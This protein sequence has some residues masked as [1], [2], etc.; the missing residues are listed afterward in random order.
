MP[1]HRRSTRSSVDLAQGKFD[2]VAA[3]STITARSRADCRLLRSLLPDRRKRWSCMPGSRHQTVDDLG[4]NTV[5]AQSGTTGEIYANDK[6]DASE[7]RGY[8]QGP[9]AINAL[10]G[11]QVDA[12][13]IDLPVGPG[14]GQ[15]AGWDRDRATRSRPTS[16]TGCRCQQDND[17]LRE[18]VNKE[19]AEMKKDG[20]S[21]GS[22]RSTSGSN[23]PAV[24][25][26]RAR[27]SRSESLR[28]E[29]AARGKGAH[30]RPLPLSVTAAA[31]GPEQRRRRWT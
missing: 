14:R 6:T 25:R 30:G 19:L 18:A 27:T 26:S 24:G 8:P 15:E 1:G 23:P 16:S 10:R 3:A 12:V 17:A 11:G 7:V 2:M 21:T 9:D 22:T 5:A 20:A 13:I 4:G 31:H 29:S 28:T